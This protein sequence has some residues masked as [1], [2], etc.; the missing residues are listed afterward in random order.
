MVSVLPILCSVVKSASKSSIRLCITNKLTV[1]SIS[2]SNSRQITREEGS[3][4]A[5]SWGKTYFTESSARH[6]ENV[7][8]IFEAMVA[9]IEKDIN[10]EVEPVAK[11][12]CSIM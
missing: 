11:G 2:F 9:E 5:A 7:V 12:G 6:N 3:A 10:P 4:L 1:F 8:K